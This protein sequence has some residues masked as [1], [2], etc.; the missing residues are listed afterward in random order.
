M[1]KEI[2]NKQVSVINKKGEEIK[3]DL[4]ETLRT[5][6]KQKL[7]INCINENAK[8]IIINN[9]E[10]KIDELTFKQLKSEVK[11]IRSYYYLELNEKG[12]TLNEVY[13]IHIE[14]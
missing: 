6:D 8:N 14:M 12:E 3:R 13:N 9:N 4:S 11:E 7:L 5:Y 2:I 10:V 1:L